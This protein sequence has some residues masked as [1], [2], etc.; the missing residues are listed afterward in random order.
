MR[1]LSYALMQLK[2]LYFDLGK[3]LVDFSV[4]RM[5]AQIAAVTGITADAARAAAMDDG[6]MRQYE[7]GRL[8]SR[9]FYE[10]FC[11]STGRR[12]DYDALAAAAS[13][14]F[15][16]KLPML[17]LVAQLRQAGYPMGI[18]SNTC[19]THWQY[20]V[21]HFRIVAEGFT[22]HALSYRIGAL[23]PDAAIF[24]AAAELAGVRPEEVFFVDDLAEHVAGARAVGFDA[25]QFTTAEMLAA[26]LRQRGLRFNY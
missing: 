2:F 14:I 9:Q 24:R 13:E 8:S 23:K 20:C 6:L 22:V 5:L 25:V 12:P 11:A 15:T 3:V 19:E 16:L 21:H 4:E 7:S 26:E 18:L 1:L 10:K 17:P